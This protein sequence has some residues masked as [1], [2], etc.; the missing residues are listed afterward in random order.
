MRIYFNVLV[1]IKILSCLSNI[2]CYDSTDFIEDTPNECGPKFCQVYCEN[3]SKLEKLQNQR[4]ILD[5]QIQLNVLSQ[6]ISILYSKLQVLENENNILQM[7]INNNNLKIQNLIEENKLLQFNLN[8]NCESIKDET[9]FFL[10]TTSINFALN[11]VFN[12]TTVHTLS[13]Y[14]YLFYL[15]F[16]Q[17]RI[18]IISNFI[19]FNLSSLNLKLMYFD[20]FTFEDIGNFT[21]YLYSFTHNIKTVQFPMINLQTILII[22]CFLFLLLF[23][24]KYILG[25][26]AFLMIVL[27]SPLLLLI[28]LFIELPRSIFKKKNYKKRKKL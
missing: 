4:I 3:E 12:M 17:Y 8:S 10:S 27:L 2:V 24:K 19:K 18:A 22:I 23:G 28:Y 1:Y 21:K 20:L 7:T 13:E 6:N 11:R 14:A 15:D 26:G 16:L 9:I 25:I 5:Q